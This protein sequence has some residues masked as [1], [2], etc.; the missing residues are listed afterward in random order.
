MEESSL[1]LHTARS[2]G[3]NS[4][5]YPDFKIG[6]IILSKH[7]GIWE[8]HGVL[9]VSKDFAKQL[10]LKKPSELES[11]RVPLYVCNCCA[12][13][14]CG[15][16]TVKVERDDGYFVWSDFGYENN[17]EDGFSQN[18][19]M[20]RTGPFKFNADLYVPVI[21]PYTKG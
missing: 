20:E 21:R 7:L 16:I 6:K 4:I 17:Y 18:A 1:E 10:L 14:G 19:Y 12:D 8:E 5:S 3:M 2:R 15:A 13:L 9:A 11:K